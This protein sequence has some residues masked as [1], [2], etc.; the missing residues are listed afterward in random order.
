MNNITA[1]LI[2][3]ILMA[4]GWIMFLGFDLSPLHIIPTIIG[5]LLIGF[6]IVPIFRGKAKVRLFR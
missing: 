2:G 3:C 1:F 6:T 4:I 5:G